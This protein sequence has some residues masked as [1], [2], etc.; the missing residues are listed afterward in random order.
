V[1]VQETVTP[2][3]AETPPLPAADLSLRGLVRLAL[4]NVRQFG[5]LAAL[6]LGLV[7]FQFTTGGVMLK[8]LNVT[9]I[10]LQNGY[11]MVMVL[12][13][14]LVIVIGHIDL[15]IGSVAGSPAPSPP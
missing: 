5:M 11:I 3:Q 13:M 1:S 7:L 6:V 15:S 4:G 2:T 10:F 12:G 8:S 14:L 9:N